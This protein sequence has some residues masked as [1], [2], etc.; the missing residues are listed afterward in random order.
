M[1]VIATVKWLLGKGRDTSYPT[2]SVNNA[3]ISD[4]KQKAE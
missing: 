4:N 2:L 1:V 3:N